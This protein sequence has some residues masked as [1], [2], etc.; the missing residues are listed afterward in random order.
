MIKFFKNVFSEDFFIKL[1]ENPI[2]PTTSQPSIGDFRRQ[3]Q[4]LANHFPDVI[5]INIS[6]KVSG[7][8]DAAKLA[9]KKNNLNNVIYINKSISN[10]CIEQSPFNAIIIE[11]AL[12][13][14]PQKLLNQLENGGRLIG[15]LSENGICNAKMFT[16]KETMFH[17]EQLFPCSLPVLPSF[18]EKNIFSF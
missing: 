16:R 6:N 12:D 3:F 11:G 17:C 13:H 18:K 5:S 7:T 4:Y 2:Y 9:T 1:K 15:I 10:G 8:F 14:V